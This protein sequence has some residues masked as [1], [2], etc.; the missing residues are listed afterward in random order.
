MLKVMPISLL[1]DSVK[2]KVVMRAI[3]LAFSIK[4]RYRSSRL[5]RFTYF[6]IAEEYHIGRATAKRLIGI[7]KTMGLVEESNNTLLFGKFKHYKENV[8]FFEIQPYDNLDLFNLIEIE[9]YLR[10]QAVYI[11]QSNIDYAVNRLQHLQNPRTPKQYKSAKRYAQTCG[12]NGSIDN[13]QSINTVSKA[14]GLGINNAVKLLNWG[15][16]KGLLVKHKRIR[17]VP[18]YSLPEGKF[19][20]ATVFTWH[21]CKFLAQSS[22]I[23]FKVL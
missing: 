15:E 16:K 6:R 12:W 5:L 21:G 19:D 11:K 1:R 2:D 17:R 9:K 20:R 13:G 23:K 8:R 22:V 4:S 14:S 7:L 3:A 18:F 10:L